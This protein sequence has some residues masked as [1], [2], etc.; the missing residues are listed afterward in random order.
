MMFGNKHNHYSENPT[1]DL[2]FIND[3]YSADVFI[4]APLNGFGAA[5]D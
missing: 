3:W 4:R 5:F 1:H 2:N